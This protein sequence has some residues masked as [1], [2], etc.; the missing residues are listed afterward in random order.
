MRST[1]AHAGGR[2]FLALAVLAALAAPRPSSAD[3]ITIDDAG[4]QG[5]TSIP[6]TCSVRVDPPL[7]LPTIG[8]V[9]RHV[10][11]F[12]LSPGDTIAF[13]LQVHD[14]SNPGRTDLG[15]RPQVDLALAHASDPANPFQPD[16]VAGTTTDFTT[17]AH[18]AIASG[19]GHQV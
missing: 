7:W 3:V 18:G 16:R 8:F 9:Y 14:S 12:H 5:T 4:Q 19:P 17:V 2:C 13:D 1:P 15:F 10:E 11:P 6:F